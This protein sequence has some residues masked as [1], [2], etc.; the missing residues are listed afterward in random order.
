M[1]NTVKVNWGL[2]NGSVKD[3][4]RKSNYQVRVG[5]FQKNECEEATTKI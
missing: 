1:L 2:N 4:A 3:P 5:W